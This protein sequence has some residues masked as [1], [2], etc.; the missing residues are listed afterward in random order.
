[1]EHFEQ[2][3]QVI[4]LT[5]G[6]PAEQVRAEM[7]REEISGWDSLGHLNLMLA[8]EDKFGL[9]LEIDDMARLTSVPAILDYLSGL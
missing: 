2:V 4:A 5:F 6:I 9:T 8:L 7:T 1:L 3:R